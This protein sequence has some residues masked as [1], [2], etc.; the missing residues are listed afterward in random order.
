MVSGQQNVGALEI[1]LHSHTLPQRLGT[2]KPIGISILQPSMQSCSSQNLHAE[3]HAKVDLREQK[4][5]EMARRLVSIHSLEMVLTGSVR[6]HVQFA[7]CAGMPDHVPHQLQFAAPCT[8]KVT[9]QIQ[10]YRNDNSSIWTSKM[11]L[12]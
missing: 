1:E 8:P 5:H 3:P 7:G 12:A 11:Q 10:K 2:Q 4:T 9:L 6:S